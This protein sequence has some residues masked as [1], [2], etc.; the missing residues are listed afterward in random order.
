M[1]FTINVYDALADQLEKKASER[2]LS[3]EEFAVHLLG[4]AVEQLEEAERWEKQNVRR[5][6][7]I[8]RSAVTKLSTEEET[9]LDILQSALDQQ[10]EPMDDRLLN[11]LDRM[12]RAVA[13]L[14]GN[15]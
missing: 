15:F 14:P 9:E 2:Q 3:V 8:R 13:N 7:L 1:M 5:L 6:D 11:E 12:K 4:K 10:L